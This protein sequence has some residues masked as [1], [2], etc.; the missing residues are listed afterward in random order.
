MR[1]LEVSKADNG[2]GPPSLA[3]TS[4]SKRKLVSDRMVNVGKMPLQA[5]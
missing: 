2:T 3:T 1:F 5:L 4:R